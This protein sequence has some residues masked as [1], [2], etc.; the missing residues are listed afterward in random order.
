VGM[1]PTMPKW[2]W[3]ILVAAVTTISA[4]A[5]DHLGQHL[6]A[7]GLWVLAVGFW[8][9]IVIWRVSRAA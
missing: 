7:V 2:R 4:D 8:V 6:V 3:V 9:A 1:I 5:S